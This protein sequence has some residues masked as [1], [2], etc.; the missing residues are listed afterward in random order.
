[1]YLWFITDIHSVYLTCNWNTEAGARSQMGGMADATVEQRKII[2]RLKKIDNFF[3][4]FLFLLLLKNHPNT[5]VYGSQN[6]NRS[7]IF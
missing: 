5:H 2:K 1:M 7:M 6:V 4:Y 3:Y